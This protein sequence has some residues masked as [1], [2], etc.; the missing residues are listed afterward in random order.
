[1]KRFYSDGYYSFSADPRQQPVQILRSLAKQF[2]INYFPHMK[3]NTGSRIL[4]IGCG[5]GG[6]LYGFREIGIRHVLGLE[7]YIDHDVRYDNGLAILS[8][9]M[10]IPDL[11]QEWDVILFNHSFEHIP[12]QHET[13]RFVYDVLA[14]KG[15]CFIRTPTVSS[16]AWEHYGIDWVGVDAP[17]HICVHSLESMNILA[18]KAR[19]SLEDVRYESTDL[20]FIGSE[21]YKRDIPLMSK[22]SHLINPQSS[23]FSP[24]QI[25]EF[26]Q[27]AQQLNLERRGDMVA[28]YLYRSC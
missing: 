9:D 23:I 14:E 6:L 20:Q 7:P 28:F 1:M 8:G 2:I 11:R 5:L 25:Q 22:E 3:L 26:R 24:E 21:Q 13:M 10:N 18:E 4:E 12:E 27:R 19:L 17:R 15:L 16:Y